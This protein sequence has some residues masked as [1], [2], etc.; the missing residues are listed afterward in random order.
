MIEGWVNGQRVHV[1]DD[2]ATVWQVATGSIFL[3][4]GGRIDL[5]GDEEP[6]VVVSQGWATHVRGKGFC[7]EFGEVVGWQRLTG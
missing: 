6:R 4:G 1:T 5:Y 7:V 2:G 3:R